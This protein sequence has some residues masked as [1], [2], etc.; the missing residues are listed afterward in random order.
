MLGRTL[1]L[2]RTQ[3]EQ[4]NSEV[5]KED[6][7]TMSENGNPQTLTETIQNEQLSA[8][9]V[10][11]ACTAQLRSAPYETKLYNPSATVFTDAL[12]TSDKGRGHGQTAM[13]VKTTSK[14]QWY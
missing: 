2:S 5:D 3:N 1:A 7:K 12:Y 8:T 11:E 13:L 10:S 6:Y 4:I 9:S 14:K